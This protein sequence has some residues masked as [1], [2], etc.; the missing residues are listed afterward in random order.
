MRADPATMIFGLRINVIT[1]VAVFLGA[2][3]YLTLVRRGREEPE[4]LAASQQ[5]AL[6]S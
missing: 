4:A 1:S 2:V 6:A 5:V 3:L